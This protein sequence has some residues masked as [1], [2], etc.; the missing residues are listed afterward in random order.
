MANASAPTDT[1]STHTEPAQ[2]DAELIEAAVSA[3]SAANPF[4]LL[5]PGQ[6]AAAAE[7]VGRAT[8]RQPSAIVRHL[9]E[10]AAESARISLGTS[11]IDLSA[12]KRFIDEQYQKNPLL[13][14]VGQQ[15]LAVTRSVHSLIDDLELDPK[16]NLRGHFV[17]SLATEALAPTN[18]LAGNPAAIREAVDTRGQSLRD[19]FRHW[20]H[21]QRT[22]GGMPSMVDTRPF[23][24]GETIATTPGVVVFRNEVLEL[25]RYAPATE[26]VRER[27]VL[28]VPPQINKYYVLDLAESRS[29]VEAAV[30]DGQQ[31]F[32]VS[33]RNPTADQS[34]WNLDHYVAALLEAID[35][36]LELTGQP[37]LNLMGVCAGG[38]TT[39]SLLGHL[40]AVSDRRVNA[41]TF[42]VTI[43]DWDVPSTIGTFTSGPAVAASIQQSQREGILSGESLGRLFAW[44]RPND[45]VWNYWVNNYLMGKNPPAFDILSWNVDATNLPAGLHAD[46]LGIASEN[47]L[48]KPNELEVLGHKVDLSTVTCD[49]Y[50]VAGYTDHITPWDGCYNTV[51]LLGGNAEF[52]LCKSGHIQ[53]LVCPEDNPKARYFTNPERA[54]DADSWKDG[55]T[56]HTGSW[57]GHWLNWMNGRAGE[58]IDA[59]TRLDSDRHPALG[60]APGHYVLD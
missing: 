19:G 53:T 2:T 57:W 5:N 43:L 48:T 26:Q 8:L 24:V 6:T 11:T 44:L 46:F 4:S 34:E 16:S 14:R 50:V 17:A 37:D 29:L 27:P 45:L 56:E 42:L 39:A 54:A 9:A 49:A 12:D 13:R 59:P 20:L 40:A 31:V 21:D 52:V 23:V 10:L 7:R 3:L 28:I 32:M 58:L 1:D 22:N 51:N 55:A 35:A 33:W 60:D 38:I 36:T 41:V 30:A 25:I 15:Y 47:S 18:T